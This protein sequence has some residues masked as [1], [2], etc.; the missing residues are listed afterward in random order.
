MPERSAQDTMRRH[1]AGIPDD[2]E[3]ATK[4][5]LAIAQ[6]ER[7]VKAGMPN[8]WAAFDEV[9]GRSGKLRAACERAGR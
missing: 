5:E 8:R 4:P 1:S 3:A 2:L 9:Y 7:L 6:V